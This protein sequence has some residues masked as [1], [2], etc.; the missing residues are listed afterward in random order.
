MHIFVRYIHLSLIFVAVRSR[1]CVFVYMYG[2]CVCVCVFICRLRGFVTD[3]LR[4]GAD[5]LL[6]YLGLTFALCSSVICVSRMAVKLHVHIMCEYVHVHRIKVYSYMYVCMC[7]CICKWNGMYAYV[8]IIYA[9]TFVSNM[10]IHMHMWTYVCVCVC[11]RARVRVQAY[12]FVLSHFRVCIHTH[13]YAS[14][15]LSK[16]RLFGG[17]RASSLRVE[18]FACASMHYAS[19][20]EYY[21]FAYMHQCICI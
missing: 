13:M 17:I 10:F 15:M 3:A 4:A 19:M 11:A 16:P 6:L 18:F 12:S 7:T 20:L 2:T 14:T 9:N 1:I 8:Y 5:L 21:T